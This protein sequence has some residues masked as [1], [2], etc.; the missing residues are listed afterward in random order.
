MNVISRGLSLQPISIKDRLS[1]GMVYIL[2]V[3]MLVLAEI[4]SPGYLSMTHM[5]GILRLAAFMG[6][7]AI[8]QTFAI[9]TGGIDLSNDKTISFAYIIAAHVMMGQND[10]IFVALCYILL[11]GII[12]GVINGAGIFLLNVPP[13]IMTLGVGSVIQGAYMIFTKGAPKGTSAPLIS[14]ISNGNIFGCVSGIVIVWIVLTAISIFV[15]RKTPYGRK[16]Y[17]VGSNR[18]ASNFSGINTKAIIFSVYIISA[19]V[20]AL[21]GFLLIGYTGMSYLH[22]GSSYGMSV[23]AAVIIGGT[24]ISGGKGGY[25]GTVA[26]AI[27]MTVLEDFLTIVNIPE[28]GRMVAQGVLILIILLLY[29]RERVKRT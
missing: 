20:S 14:S 25:L 15:L 16:I 19:V 9:L 18:I 26:G 22:A 12:V 6:I 23:I 5:M 21:M 3:L 13:F 24:A 27:M 7:A 17:S 4:F 1:S 2:L 11:F 29:A 8:G 10:N 28:A